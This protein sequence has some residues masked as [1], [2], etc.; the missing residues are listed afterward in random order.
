MCK[1]QYVFLPSL[2]PRPS[3][4]SQTGQAARP[5]YSGPDAGAAGH[6]LITCVLSPTPHTPAAPSFLSLQFLHAHQVPNRSRRPQGRQ[7]TT[8]SLHALVAPLWD[9]SS[10]PLS[11]HVSVCVCLPGTPGMGTLEGRTARVCAHSAGDMVGPPEICWPDKRMKQHKTRNQC[12]A[13]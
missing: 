10:H 11:G 8:L 7:P 9:L 3:L 12:L 6:W 13:G 5:F 2:P 4:H 1:E